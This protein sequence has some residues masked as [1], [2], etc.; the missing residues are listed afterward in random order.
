MAKK[1]SYERYAWFHG[2]VKADVFPN[3]THLAG[4]FEIS[5]KQAQ[6]DIEFMRERL[7]APLLY[8]A[9]HRGYGYKEGNYELPPFL[10][11][12]KEYIRR[13]FYVITGERSTDVVLCFTP[14][15]SPW[16][17]EQEWHEAQDVS[18]GKDGSLRLRFPVSGFGEVA[19][20]IL[21]YGAAVEVLEPKELRDAIREEI[22]KMGTLYR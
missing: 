20:E 5:H 10:P 11:P 1:L 8:T 13:N 4:R 21:K 3:S 15:V 16:I 9:D 17:A 6:R 2:R 12:I 18:V 7:S 22:R 14:G 19:R